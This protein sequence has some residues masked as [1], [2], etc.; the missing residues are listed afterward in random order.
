M[1]MMVKKKKKKKKKREEEEMNCGRGG[2]VI[3]HIFSSLS[4]VKVKRLPT[5][6]RSLK[7]NTFA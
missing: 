7:V 1:M 3:N 2:I 6:P 5:S 4:G